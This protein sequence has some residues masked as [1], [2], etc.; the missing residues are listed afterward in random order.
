MF[1]CSLASTLGRQFTFSC[2]PTLCSV[3]SIYLMELTGG[4]MLEQYTIADILNWLADRTLVVNREFQRSDRIWPTAARTYLIDT[5]LR[6]M[7][8]PK[9]YIRTQTD[10]N[11]K[12]SYR[13]VVD[14][15]QRLM[16][17]KSFA[18]D[19]FALRPSE[20]DLEELA[21]KRYSELGED[22]KLKFLEYPLPV[23]Q[24]FNATDAY[25]FDVF[26]RL[27]TYNFN[28]S[29]QELRHGKYH[30]SFRNSVIASSKRW[31][32]LWDKY[33]VIGKRARVRMADDELMAQF[34]GVMLKGVTDGGQPKIERLYRNYDTELP[35]RTSGQVDRIL[36]YIAET[37]PDILETN[38]A[39]APHFLMLF[40]AVAHA[41]FGIPP[42]DIR[43]E[44]PP[45]DTRALSDVEMAKVNLSTLADILNM[46]PDEAP[47]RFHKFRLASA[48]STQ[49]IR[50][51]RVRFLMSFKSL[52]PD[53][54]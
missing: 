44:M 20:D 39:R 21:G 48:G 25:V 4:H 34:F 24:L 14:G 46:D 50:S 49:R 2:F 42:G 32:F 22:A 54:I 3:H 29:A 30:G 7:P 5:I 52:L 23:E 10:V 35:E 18:Q 1:F 27:N 26:Q 12:R 38:L 41:K 19:E 33:N 37:M 16:A 17:I 40:S 13:E 11:T 6:G 51:R 31:A 53:Q 36:E 15:Q 47:E 45:R 8:I 43:D 9:I 28:L